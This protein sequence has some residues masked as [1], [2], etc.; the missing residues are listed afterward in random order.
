[1]LFQRADAALYTAKQDW[2]EPRSRLRKA[3]GA[4]ERGRLTGSCR[5]YLVG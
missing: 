4:R 2:A 1:M 3:G 5:C